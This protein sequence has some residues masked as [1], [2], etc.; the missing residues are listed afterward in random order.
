MLKISRILC[1]LLSLILSTNVCRAST[2]EYE[3]V[4][5]EDLVRQIS[6]K[7][8]NIE[9][10]RQP[11]PFDQVMIHSGVGYV[12]S[13]TVMDI[14]NRESQK[15]QNGIELSLGVDLFSPNWYAETSFRN[16]GVTSYGPQEIILKELDL[17]VGFKD[18]L[19]KPFV[20]KI[21]GGLANRYLKINDS[22]RDVAINDTTPMLLGTVGIAAE[23]SPLI[24]LGVNFS[25][26]SAL[27]SRT[28]DKSAFDFSFCFSASL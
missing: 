4:G 14:Q 15:Y 19:Q 3:E 16:F 13:F 11:H 12:N 8:K 2:A 9:D 18:H 1:L 20:F 22:D 28:A 25:G 7:K 21:D 6:S 24:S 26:K 27:I 5:Y 10:R 23:L 17:K